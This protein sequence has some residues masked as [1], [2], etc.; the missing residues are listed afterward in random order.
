MGWFENYSAWFSAIIFVLTTATIAQNV[1]NRRRSNPIHPPFA[2]NDVLFTEKG[3]SGAV[4]H[5]L[6]TRM[7]GASNGLIIT[8]LRQGLLIE[9]LAVIKWVMRSNVNGLEHFVSHS[10]ITRAAPDGAPGKNGVRVEF[11]DADGRPIKL[12]LYL[13][14]RDQFLAAMAKCTAAASVT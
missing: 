4:D 7:S 6:F 2:P 11:R 1:W 13:R 12:I 14:Y 9:P 8:V 10:D 3:A 5:N